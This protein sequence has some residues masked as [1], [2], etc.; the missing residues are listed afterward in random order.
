MEN[1]SDTEPGR[2]VPANDNNDASDQPDAGT[3]QRV[4]RAALT[5]ARIIGRQMAREDFERLNA[6][7][8][9]RPIV[10]EKTEDEAGDKD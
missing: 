8:D 3:W 10:S 9:N 5:L 1:E 7:N 4:D 6:A 2:I